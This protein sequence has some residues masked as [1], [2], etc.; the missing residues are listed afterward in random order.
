MSNVIVGRYMSIGDVVAET[1][2]SRA[3]VYR[4]IKKGRF[5]NRVQLSENR[6]AWC[7]DAVQAWKSQRIASPPI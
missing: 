6:V 7:G 1:S 5:P 2:L 4:L 3:T